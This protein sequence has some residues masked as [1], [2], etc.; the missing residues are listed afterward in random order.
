[1]Y[2]RLRLPV[3]DTIAKKSIQELRRPP[4][5]RFIDDQC[6]H[7]PGTRIKSSEFTD[8]FA[9]WQ[10]SEEGPSLT[11]GMVSRQLPGDCPQGYAGGHKWIGN[12]S[13]ENTPAKDSRPWVLMGRELHQ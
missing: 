9:A 3:I 8:R 5:E 4:V 13:W 6:F 1:M 7:V 10:K 12:L 2:K 11:K